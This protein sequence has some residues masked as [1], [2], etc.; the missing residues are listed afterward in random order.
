MPESTA[1]CPRLSHGESGPGFVVVV[2]TV[3]LAAVVAAVPMGCSGGYDRGPGGVG[4]GDCCL[5]HR[6][7]FSLSSCLHVLLGGHAA[8][9]R[10]VGRCWLSWCRCT[11]T[12]LGGHVCTLH[13][14][15]SDRGRGARGRGLAEGVGLGLSCV[16]VVCAP[17]VSDRRCWPE[18]LPPAGP[19]ARL[20]MAGRQ[21]QRHIR[22][23]YAALRVRWQQRWVHRVAAG[24]LCQLHCGAHGCV[25]FGDPGPLRVLRATHCCEFVCVYVCVMA[26]CHPRWVLAECWACGW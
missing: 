1:S 14:S 18:L 4:D 13:C 24:V 19:A 10:V 15:A 22:W 2:V 26:P 17:C 9:L 7:L 25:G 23:G 16:C 6:V 20:P 11:C 8:A 12:S 3:A 21:P 5:G